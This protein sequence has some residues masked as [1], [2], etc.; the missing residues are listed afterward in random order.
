ML[1]Y[2][3]EQLVVVTVHSNH[4]FFLVPGDGGSQLDAK[5]SKSQ[6]VHYVCEKNSNDY[7]NIWL[8]L[9]LLVPIVIDCWVCPM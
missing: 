3:D 9:E 5:L 2:K 4:S 8:N 6:V 7:F 1:S